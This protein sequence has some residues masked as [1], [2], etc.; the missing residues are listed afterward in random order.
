LKAEILTLKGNAQ[1][2]LQSEVEKLEKKAGNPVMQTPKGQ[3]L[4]QRE[5]EKL[6]VKVEKTK[7]LENK[8]SEQKAET[9]LEDG[10]TGQNT[11][12]KPQ[13]EE[14]QPTPEGQQEKTVKTLKGTVKEMVDQGLADSNL[15]LEEA[16]SLHDAHKSVNSSAADLLEQSIEGSGLSIEEFKA[17]EQEYKSVYNVSDEVQTLKAELE[18][19]GK[20]SKD[21]KVKELKARIEEIEAPRKARKKELAEQLKPVREKMNAIETARKAKKADLDE[22]LQNVDKNLREVFNTEADFEKGVGLQSADDNLLTLDD[23]KG[24]L[25]EKQ[26]AKAEKLW[27]SLKSHQRRRVE[28]QAEISGRSNADQAAKITKSGNVK[29]P[30]TDFSPIGFVKNPKGVAVRGYNENGFLRTYYLTETAEGSVIQTVG[31]EAGAAFQGPV[32]RVGVTPGEYKLADVLGRGPDIP[33]G[34]KT[35]EAMASAKMRFD[36]IMALKESVVMPQPVAKALDRI[37]RTGK[38]SNLDYKL[39][40]KHLKST[41][42]EAIKKAFCDILGLSH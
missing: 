34:I 18:A 28:Y 42:S 37:A 32:A 33:D 3:A 26:L 10:A 38:I 6:R 12:N 40:N 29:I 19:F 17:L 11:E 13:G 23:I 25:N 5:A 27:E 4:V 14:G 8:G 7:K 31:N 21:P 2:T 30:R 24:E 22:Q 41:K 35:S 36:Q 39:I 16:K 1:K 15:T 20:G 9:E